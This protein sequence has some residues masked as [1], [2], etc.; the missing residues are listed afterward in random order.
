MKRAIKK[1]LQTNDF[2]P[3]DKNKWNYFKI[4]HKKKT[5]KGRKKIWR[6]IKSEVK[7]F[8]GVYIYYAYR[9]KGKPTYIGIGKRL[10]D[11]LYSHYRISFEEFSND[12]TGEWHKFWSRNKGIYTV[13]WKRL[14]MEKDRKMIEQ[15]LH[16]ILGSKFNDWRLKMRQGRG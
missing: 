13:Y 11:R 12:R 8:G 5:I 10:K 6:Y 4:E 15:L 16:Y 1:F 14:K 7:N 9:N 2:L 3:V